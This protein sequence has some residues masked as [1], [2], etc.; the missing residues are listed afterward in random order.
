LARFQKNNHIS[1]DDDLVRRYL[2][3]IG[4]HPLLAKADEARLATLVET[5]QA[6]LKQIDDAGCHGPVTLSTS[7]QRQLKAAVTAGD[8]AAALFVSSNLRLVV[9]IAKRYQGSGLP[10]LDLIQE[11]NLGLIHAVAKFD[12]HKGFKFS[13]YA[14]WWIRQGISRG[15]SNT[16]RVI[17]LP[18]HASDDAVVLRRTSEEMMSTLGRQPTTDELT[19]TLGWPDGRVDTVRSFAEEPLSLSAAFAPE[20]D[21]EIG[22]LLADRNA[23]EPDEAAVLASVAINVDTLLAE[24]PDRDRT[25]LRL[26]YGLDGGNPQTLDQVGA[27]LHLSRERIRQIE[28]KAMAKLR[29]PSSDGHDRRRELL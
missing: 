12:H 6:A 11:G 2:A 19:A 18:I 14:T 15:I 25:V 10:L 20:G 3:D 21:G 4:R 29:Q 27:R 16:G 22:D 13:T 28:A 26:R 7:R 17:R 1:R 23:V 5:G 8:D 24:L 9:S